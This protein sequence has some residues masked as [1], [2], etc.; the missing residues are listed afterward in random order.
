MLTHIF[1]FIV[2]FIGDHPLAALA[3]V[4]LISAG[5]ALFVIGLFVPST[6]VLVGAG[7][8]V[9]MGKLPFVPIYVAASLGA[10]AGDAASYWIGHRYK[11]HIRQIW[12]FSRYTLLLDKGEAFFARHGGKSVFIGRFIPG[13]KSVVPGVAGI[14]GMSPWRFSII[15]V[16]SAFAWAASHILPGMGIGRAV[17][18][19]ASGNPRLLELAL[20]LVA[21]VTLTWYVTKIAVLWMLPHL[22]IWRR[23]AIERLDKSDFKGALTLRRLLANEEGIFVP[24]ALA[25][26]ASAALIGFLAVLAQFLFDPE[27]VRSDT[28]ISTYI[29]TLRTPL[30]DRFMVAVTMFGDAAVMAPV[31]VAAV[32][33]VALQRRWRLAGALTVAF[34]GATAFVPMVKIFIHRARPIELYQGADGFSFPSGHAT[35]SATIIGVTLLIA[36][37][38]AQLRVRLGVFLA[39]AVAIAMVGFSRL[40]L[41]A[42]WPSDV[43]A[44]LLFGTSLVLLLAWL[45]HGKPLAPLSRNMALA[46]V[47]MLALAYPL[48]I[49]RD[50]ATTVV[51]YAPRVSQRIVANTE[52][53]QD[54]VMVGPT[55][56]VLLNGEFG[57]PMLVQTDATMAD[58][59]EAL[60]GAGWTAREENQLAG[61]INAILP[62]RALAAQF[63]P[64]PHTHQGRPPVAIFSRPAESGAQ[65]VLRLW[66]TSTVISIGD[67]K[68][69]LHAATF[70]LQATDMLPFGFTLPDDAPLLPS[71][72][73]AAASA[74]AK[75]IASKAGAAV[76]RAGSVQVVATR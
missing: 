15:N 22:D 72:A 7:T 58:I 59:S 39:G 63:I 44:G 8:L 35:M 48:H 23:H 17:D 56:R 1:D 49:Y 47:A 9:G 62:A 76:V 73:Q 2:T 67:A 11:E 26:M 4:F 14:V 61:L 19:T 65:L 16:V 57:E 68:H 10:V 74:A 32:I 34:V 64:M 41:H 66:D 24:F 18:V 3:I 6:V 71:A 38:G 42:H 31:A 70:S 20:I 25:A 60:R 28:A 33:V 29:Q 40:Y 12:P 51:R 21:V 13:V 36:A 37:H 30:F 46:T 27:F 55:N 54:P 43:M 69:P 50:F 5:E 45:L 53:L 52:W 75:A